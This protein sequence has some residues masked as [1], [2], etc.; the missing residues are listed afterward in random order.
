MTELKTLFHKTDP[1]TSREAAE[2]MVKSGELNR[3]E[4]EVHKAIVKFFSVPD[5]PFTARGLAFVSNIDYFLIQ[6][7]LSGLHNKG[8]V[9]RIQA[10]DK[11]KLLFNKKGKPIYEKRDGCCV[12]RLVK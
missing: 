8:K 6:R 7:R 3:Q 2:K 4:K 12:W 11:G 9:E 5:R 1:E 10:T